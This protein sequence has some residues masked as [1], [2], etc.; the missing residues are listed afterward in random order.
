MTIRTRNPLTVET[1]NI[2]NIRT[3]S[4]QISYLGFNTGYSL[5][6]NNTPP[7]HFSLHI[8]SFVLPRFCS[9]GWVKPKTSILKLVHHALIKNKESLKKMQI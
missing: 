7:R 1:I 2:I 8:P 5:N 9:L 4:Q 6:E 3:A